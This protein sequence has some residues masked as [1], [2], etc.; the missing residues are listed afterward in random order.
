MTDLLGTKSVVPGLEIHHTQLK[1]SELFSVLWCL[2]GTF[3]FLEK[4]H[5]ILKEQCLD[6]ERIQHVESMMKSS[7]LH[8]IALHCVLII[9]ILSIINEWS[10]I[11]HGSFQIITQ[12]WMPVWVMSLIQSKSIESSGKIP[13]GFSKFWISICMNFQCLHILME[14]LD[15]QN[16]LLL[17]GYAISTD[18]LEIFFGCSWNQEVQM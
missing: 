3:F 2:H 4:Q 5:S 11:L 17:T 18:I 14:S 13:I 7:S 8:C 12:I 9:L 1:L 6:I 15:F 16:S 10:Q